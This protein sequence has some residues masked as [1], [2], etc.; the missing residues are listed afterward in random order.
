MLL[1][2]HELEINGHTLYRDHIDE[3]LFHIMPGPPVVRVRDGQSALEFVRYRGGQAGGLLNVEFE[4]R[5]DEDELEAVREALRERFGAVVVVPVLF[6]RGRARL[7]VLG[8]ATRN[9]GAETPEGQGTW[10]VESLMGEAVPSLLGRQ[11]AIFAA[12]LSPEGAALV[13]AALHGDALPI[14]AVYE[15]EYA[16]L[17]RARG[18]RATVDFQMAYEYLTARFG[19]NS[20][21]F[22]AELGDEAEAL[23]EMGAI[24]IEDIDFVGDDPA[25][26]AERSREV[27]E[28]LRELHETLFYVPTGSPATIAADVATRDA[29]VRQ[30]WGATGM[31]AAAFRLRVLQQ[32]EQRTLT[33][34]LTSDRVAT[35]SVAPQAPLRLQESAVVRTLDLER[36]PTDTRVRIVTPSEADW[37]GVAALQAD[38][39]AG[40]EV[41]SAVLTAQNRDAVLTLPAAPL[42]YRVSALPTDAPSTDAPSTEAP[43]TDAPSTDRPP[44]DDAQEF[45]SLSHPVLQLD[46]AN[47]LGIRRVRLALGAVELGQDV[48]VEVRAE[49]RTGLQIAQLTPSAPE[50]VLSLEAREDVTLAV[51]THRGTAPAVIEEHRVLASDNLVMINPSGAAERSLWVELRDPL[52]RYAQV[53]VE[54]EGAATDRKLVS[55]DDAHP[56]KRVAVPNGDLRYRVRAVRRDAQVTESDWEAVDGSLLLVG[57]S[58]VRIEHIE[59]IVIA[60]EPLQGVFLSLTVDPPALGLPAR[61]DV[62]LEPG[63]TR[64]SVDLAFT[65]D[66]E[67]RFIIEGQAFGASGAVTLSSRIE[68]G[69]VV[70][71]ETGPVT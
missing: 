26:A 5:R 66:A 11:T 67:R 22:R 62:L 21:V 40:A 44:A 45:R 39:R 16:G 10:L 35:R 71:L 32:D 53:F 64:F 15:L 3:G 63:Q 51:A 49:T 17:K 69:E 57:D 55:L 59:G 42:E 38:V 29:E 54:I 18:V 61:H 14:L 30:T 68:T 1:L 2:D 31:A 20:L 41:R 52:L 43:S 48:T 8:T 27:L 37:E 50:A 12:T 6:N 19:L 33:Y 7:T 58:D 65:R 24:Q 4:L 34:D 70:L 47:L 9:E 56:S 46:P 28:T 23:R 25:A 13:D 36:A 60:D